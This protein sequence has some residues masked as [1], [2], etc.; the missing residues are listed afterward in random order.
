MV[1]RVN[2]PIK[3][4]KFLELKAYKYVCTYGYAFRRALS[5]S[6]VAKKKCPV[7]NRFGRKSPY[8]KGSAL[9]GLKI[10]QGSP[11]VR[12]GFNRSGISMATK[13]S[14]KNP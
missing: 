11:G 5:R 10:M 7:A 12:Q 13:F 8:P 14:R 6:Q 1:N 4:A 9:I 3:E 2:I